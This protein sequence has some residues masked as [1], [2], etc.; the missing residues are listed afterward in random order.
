MLG[1]VLL[2]QAQAA[3]PT[4]VVTDPGVIAT[5][6]RV[7]P[8]GLQSVFEGRVYG[9]R[10]GRTADEI[11]VA[12]PGAATLLDWRSNRLIARAVVD[13]R[14]GVYGATTDRANGRVYVSSV[15]KLLATP[16]PTGRDTRPAVAQ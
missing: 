12:A 15:G 5:G 16:K 6:Q 13:G 7:S 11:W 4:R 1:L 9:V 3:T 10:F 2:L 14:P 8:A